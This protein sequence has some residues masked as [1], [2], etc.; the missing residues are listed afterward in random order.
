MRLDPIL[1]MRDIYIDYNLKSVIKFTSSS[2]STEFENIIPCSISQM[3]RAIVISPI[4]TR[5]VISYAIKWGIG[6][7]SPLVVSIPT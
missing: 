4:S 3:N 2:R 5:I 6:N 1:M 7:H